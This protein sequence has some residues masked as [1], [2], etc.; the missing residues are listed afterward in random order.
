[1]Q[2]LL[3]SWKIYKFAMFLKSAQDCLIQQI[4]NISE[5]FEREK[6]VVKIKYNIKSK[7][8]IHH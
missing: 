4:K 8:K 3:M 2:L 6:K 1:M 7:Y 5:E